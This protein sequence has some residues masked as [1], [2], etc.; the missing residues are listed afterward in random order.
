MKVTAKS[1]PLPLIETK[2][3][4]IE[5]GAVGIKTLPVGSEY[6]DK[7]RREVQHLPEFHLLFL[8]LLFRLLTLFN[9]DTG[10]V[11]SCYVPPLIFKG[12][13][14]DQKA[15]I[16]TIVPQHPHFDLMGRP[17]EEFFIFFDEIP[18]TIIG[19]NKINSRWG[20]QLIDVDTEIL[21]R[22]AIGVEWLSIR[23]KYKDLCWRKVQNLPKLHF[24]CLKL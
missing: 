6:S 24:L 7:L 14:A 8:K 2:A 9:V 16:R 19:M 20:E 1:F 15:S 3:E 21:E 10:A 4:V 12:T 18:F 5:Q 23:P 11:P 13:S 17:T 22:Y